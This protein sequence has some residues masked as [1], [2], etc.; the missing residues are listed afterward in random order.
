MRVS[1]HVGDDDDD[2]VEQREH[3]GR[4]AH[5]SVLKRLCIFVVDVG[6]KCCCVVCE[7][8]GGA[9]SDACRCRDGIAPIHLAARGGH[10]STVELLISKNVDVNVQDK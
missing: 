5:A 4:H 10:V 2:D 7:I 1:C 8:E 3:D 6:G 9:R